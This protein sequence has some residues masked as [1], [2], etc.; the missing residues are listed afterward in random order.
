MKM[1]E[2]A[3]LGVL[4]EQ[5]NDHMLYDSFQGPPVQSDTWIRCYVIT[6]TG[7]FVGMWTP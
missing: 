5:A 4:R 1:T 2:K 6:P 7:R 3:Y